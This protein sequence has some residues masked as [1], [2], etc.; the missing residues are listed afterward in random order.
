MKTRM[1][2]R[3][4]RA[5]FESSTPGQDEPMVNWATGW[6]QLTDSKRQALTER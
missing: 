2:W 1:V 3:V 4:K 5:S 6:V